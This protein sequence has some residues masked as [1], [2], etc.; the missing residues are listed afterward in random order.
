MTIVVLCRQSEPNCALVNQNLAQ[1][2]SHY[3]TV[4]KLQGKPKEGVTAYEKALAHDPKV[5]VD[6]TR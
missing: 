5:L 3:G 2:L 6:T 1:A 4:M